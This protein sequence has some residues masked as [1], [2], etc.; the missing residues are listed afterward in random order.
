MLPR[1]SGVEVLAELRGDTA[2]R[3]TPVVVITAWTHAQQAAVAAGADRFV[4]KP[5]DPDE[6]K[7]VVDELLRG[8]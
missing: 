6:L 1:M 7:A 8:S 5:F 2:I 4:A 3:D